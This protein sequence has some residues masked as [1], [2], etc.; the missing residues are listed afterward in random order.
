[1]M[2][3]P[4]QAGSGSRTA[5]MLPALRL[6]FSFGTLVGIARHGTGK[7]TLGSIATTLSL[8]LLPGHASRDDHC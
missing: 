7:A 8:S 6:L 4:S 5:Y 2:T 1:M 3:G